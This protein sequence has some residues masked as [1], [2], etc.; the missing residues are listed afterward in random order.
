VKPS[1]TL[2][3]TTLSVG[4][5]L[6]LCRRDGHY[7]LRVAARELMGTVAANSEMRLAA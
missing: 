2:A 4:A 1:V 6:S 3:E 7:F 5:T